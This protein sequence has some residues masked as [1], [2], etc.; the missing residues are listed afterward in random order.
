M[1]SYAELMKQRKICANPDCRIEF[2][3]LPSHYKHPELWPKKI[4]HEPACGYAH[5]RALLLAERKTCENTRCGK[6]FGPS[7]YE[8]K[9][10]T[11]WNNRKYCS[12]ECSG[13]ASGTATANGKG[14]RPSTPLEKECELNGCSVVM[15]QKDWE[16]PGR[17]KERRFCSRVHASEHKRLGLSE[18]EKTKTCALP[19]CDE[20]LTLQPDER[21]A[22]FRARQYHSD[23]C[24]NQARAARLAGNTY[25]HDAVPRKPEEQRSWNTYKEKKKVAPPKQLEQPAR[26]VPPG[27]T[28]RPAGFSRTPRIPAHIREWNER[29]NLKEA[30]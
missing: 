10:R 28:W 6:Q 20:T 12:Q 17:F 29:N 7:E 9:R 11:R 25:R 14:P 21:L 3:P 19:G 16:S 13:V 15:V 18:A 24:R 23:L 26:P 27:E 4:Y 2:G 30:G 5:Q 8:L 22:V 1:T